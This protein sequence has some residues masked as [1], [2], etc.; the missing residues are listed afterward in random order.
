MSAF[1]KSVGGG[2]DDYVMGMRSELVLESVRALPT[3]QT[4]ESSFEIS[5]DLGLV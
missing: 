1:F 3:N 4:V 5:K 2:L